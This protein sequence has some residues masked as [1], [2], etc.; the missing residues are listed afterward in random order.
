MATVSLAGRLNHFDQIKQNLS[1]VASIATS[2]CDTTD[3]SFRRV[4]VTKKD[5]QGN[6]RFFNVK[7]ASGNVTRSPFLSYVEHIKTGDLQLDEPMDV[8]ALKCVTI[9]LSAP[10][11]TFG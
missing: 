11:Y 3:S 6:M 9:A 7:D 8:V 5:A 10:F 4:H 2:F 1:A